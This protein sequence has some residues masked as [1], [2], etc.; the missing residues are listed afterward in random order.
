MSFFTAAELAEARGDMESELGPHTLQILR[1]IDSDSDTG[2]PDVSEQYLTD[3]GGHNLNV[4]YRCRPLRTPRT[5]PDG[6]STIVVADWEIKLPASYISQMKQGDRLI[7]S[8]AE[9]TV[10]FVDDRPDALLCR[11]EVLKKEPAR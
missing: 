7:A 9:Y 1:Q 10:F 8:D 11:L 6:E 4:A 3:G 2:G 5:R